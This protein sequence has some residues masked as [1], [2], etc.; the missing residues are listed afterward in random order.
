LSVIKNPDINGIPGDRYNSTKFVQAI[1]FGIANLVTTSTSFTQGDLIK[2]TTANGVVAFANTS[3]MYVA[4]V[5]GTFAT[6]QTL[7][8]S[9]LGGSTA[10]DSPD[11][12][13]RINTAVSVP[14][15]NTNSGQVLYYQN[16][17]PSQRNTFQTE[18]FRLI[19]KV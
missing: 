7:N 14:D 15:I 13:F 18:N 11:G 17:L 19:V 8:P 5:Q 4:N 3:Y 10:A 9:S 1:G 6:T 16:I 2:T 12:K